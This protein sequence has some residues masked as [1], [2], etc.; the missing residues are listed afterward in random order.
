MVDPD[1]IRELLLGESPT[2]LP[3]DVSYLFGKQLEEADLIVLNK[4]DQ[5]RTEESNDLPGLLRHRFPAKKVLP[6][7]A[8]EGEGMEAWLELLVTGR[9]GAKT[10]LIRSTMTATLGPKQSWA[11]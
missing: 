3:E 10:V 9:P 8:L 7:S 1:R 5:L 6:I 4:I 2:T 11:G